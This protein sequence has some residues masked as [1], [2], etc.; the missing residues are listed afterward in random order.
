MYLLS[1]GQSYLAKNKVRVTKSTILTLKARYTLNSSIS[2]QPDLI[3]M[4][5]KIIIPSPESY[6]QIKFK[7]LTIFR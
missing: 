6:N 3:V 1:K 5:H 4:Y 7:C 2:T